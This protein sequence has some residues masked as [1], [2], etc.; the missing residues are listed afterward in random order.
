MNEKEFSFAGTK[1]NGFAM[2]FAN[3][4]NHGKLKS[5]IFYAKEAGFTNK[6]IVTYNNVFRKIFREMKYHREIEKFNGY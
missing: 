1:L 3:L 6:E 5:L 2:L 4:V